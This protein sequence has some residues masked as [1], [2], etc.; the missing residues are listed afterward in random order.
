MGWVQYRHAGRLS[1]KMAAEVKVNL[2]KLGILL[3][4]AGIIV[5]VIPIPYSYNYT[6]TEQYTYQVPYTDYNT[7]N[8]LT[9]NSTVLWEQT[10]RTETFQVAN[11]CQLTYT[12]W[13]DWCTVNLLKD[14]VVILT[15]PPS[16]QIYPRSINVTKGNYWFEFTNNVTLNIGEYTSSPYMTV[17]I[18]EP[19]TKY[20]TQTGWRDVPHTET[21]WTFPYTNIGIL[22]V[23]IGI[24][25]VVYFYLEEKPKRMPQIPKI[26]PYPYPTLFIATH[27]VKE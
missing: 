18:Q 15:L 17:Y 24:V 2:K 26:T 7:V 3:I 23:V 11:D 25:L 1:K 21:I 8:T 9:F 4:V 20:T 19:V 16:M 5:A 13:T 10:T 27:T 14:G 6:T 12:G 22:I